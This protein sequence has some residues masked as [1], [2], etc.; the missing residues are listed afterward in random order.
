[1]LRES[2][3]RILSSSLSFATIPPR[4]GWLLMSMSEPSRILLLAVG[5]DA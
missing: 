2:V 4:S 5:L 3:M 1:M